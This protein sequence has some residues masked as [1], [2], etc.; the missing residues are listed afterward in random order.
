MSYVK[1]LKAMMK[2]A[3]PYTIELSDDE[4]HSLKYFA[5][6]GYDCGL[7]DALEPTDEEGKYTIS[8]NKMWSINEAC[9]EHGAWTNLN[10]QSS[11]GQKIHKLLESVV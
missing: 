11:L 7:L 10:W 3:G 5:D 8:E 2:K 6:K 1:Q 4:V 9:S